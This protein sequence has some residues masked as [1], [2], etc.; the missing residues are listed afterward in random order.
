MQKATEFSRVAWDTR[1]GY[2]DEEPRPVYVGNYDE[3]D[4]DET[5]RQRWTKPTTPGAKKAVHSKEDPEVFKIGRYL[6]C[7][8]P[9][10]GVSV[11]VIQASKVT[12]HFKRQWNYGNNPV[13]ENKCKNEHVYKGG[14]SIYHHTTTRA[15]ARFL[16]PRR[17]FNG[18]TV[19]EKAAWEVSRKFN[20]PNGDIVNLKPDV[21]VGFIDDTYFAIEV[22][23]GH[24][25]ERNAHDAYG[26]NM[27]EIDLKELGVVD[28]EQSFFKW[29]REG[30]IEKALKRNSKEKKRIQ[31]HEK[32]QE[33][34]ERDDEKQYLADRKKEIT[35]CIE[36]Y[37]F[38]IP[39]EDL[40]RVREIKD[41]KGLF[42]K[43]KNIRDEELEKSR[44]KLSLINEEIERNVEKFG[45]RLQLGPKDSSSVESVKEF[46]RSK[47]GDAWRVADLENRMRTANEK[48]V[49]ELTDKYDSIITNLTVKS[50][51]IL[52]LR[53]WGGEAERIPNKTIFRQSTTRYDEIPKVRSW[54]RDRDP[55]KAGWDGHRAFKK[56]GLKE[57]SI[58]S[59]F[60]D[61]VDEI[62]NIPGSNHVCFLIDHVG[63]KPTPVEVKA[64]IISI[65]REHKEKFEDYYRWLERLRIEV[66]EW[67]SEEAFVHF[68]K[69]IGEVI[70]YRKGSNQLESMIQVEKI[71]NLGVE[72][73]S[74][75]LDDKDFW[76]KP[77]V[78][79]LFNGLGLNEIWA[80]WVP[81]KKKRIAVNT[82]KEKLLLAVTA[83]N[84]GEYRKTLTGPGNLLLK[85][86]LGKRD[87]YAAKKVVNIRDESKAERPVE[88]QK[89]EMAKERR[90]ADHVAKKVLKDA[91]EGAEAALE[92]AEAAAEKTESVI[93]EKMAAATGKLEL[94]QHEKNWADKCNEEIRKCESDYRFK[95]D[96]PVHELTSI[97]EIRTKFS[98][99]GRLPGEPFNP[100]ARDASAQ[101]NKRMSERSQ[102]QP[103][104]VEEPT[105]VTSVK[106]Q[107]MSA[108]KVS[109]EDRMAELRRKSEESRKN[110]KKR[111]F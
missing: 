73:E 26:A 39:S 88:Y 7:H 91:L 44:A 45:E 43:E 38:D 2:D 80:L 63:V 58:D 27:V 65:F 41:I 18:K 37:G 6:C 59:E 54:R 92:K 32:R 105:S 24:P 101:R 14:E 15:V 93:L 83:L 102:A 40:T 29:I 11:K 69:Y 75:L 10:C 100:F 51:I 20:L 1:R 94:E 23:F 36:T 106:K 33:M 87:N 28:S 96:I 61:E 97:S 66:A 104:V 19:A 90:R 50:E 84:P 74:S 25:P 3:W 67:E 30:G 34:F 79:E 99:A 77:G 57:H 49:K 72:P 86:I 17:K 52:A 5:K 110:A 70:G 47:L 64:K 8:D 21:Y 48:E 71:V 60:L 111:S 22:V 9:E 46:Y 68:W 56:V 107:E 81:L 16:T 98:Q 62:C 108:P 13:Y 55:W 31:R 109:R 95:L 35:R 78:S 76:E 42:E 4:P 103:E 89:E 85:H 12:W 82:K 53:E